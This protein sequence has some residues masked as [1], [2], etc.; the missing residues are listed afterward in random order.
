MIRGNGLGVKKLTRADAKLCVIPKPWTLN[1]FAS[2]S[3]T[4]QGAHC[5]FA[6]FTEP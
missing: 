2:R 1:P 6:A 4:I 5:S 3:R